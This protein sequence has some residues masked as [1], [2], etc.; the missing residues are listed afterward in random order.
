MIIVN[1]NKYEDVLSKQGNNT[2]SEKCIK[3][4]RE[5]DALVITLRAVSKEGKVFHCF[6][7][8]DEDCSNT[9]KRPVE[10]TIQAINSFIIN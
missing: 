2:K 5:K 3:W 7:P 6:P 4:K 8:S 9:Q 1:T 10:I